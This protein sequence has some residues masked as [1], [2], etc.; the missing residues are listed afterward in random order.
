MPK[1]AT[2]AC[3][4]KESSGVLIMVLDG[5]AK[6]SIDLTDFQGESSDMAAAADKN[7]TS[8]DPNPCKN[9]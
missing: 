9:K 7:F 5:T 4:P 2:D 8:S 6:Y 1:S 3:N